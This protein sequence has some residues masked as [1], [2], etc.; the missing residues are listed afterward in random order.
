MWI[1]IKN[2]IKNPSDKIILKLF[3]LYFILKPFYFWE[4]G[5]PQIADFFLILAIVFYIFKKRFLIRFHKGSSSYIYINL[6]FVF[7][8]L[9]V[10][11]FWSLILNGELDFYKA[12]AFYFF[13][14]MAS[15]FVVI[16]YW[17]YED[18]IFQLIYSS[19]LSSIIIQFAIYLFKGGFR[20]SRVLVFFNNPNQLGYY[21]LLTLAILLY[22]SFKMKTITV[23]FFIGIF[24]ATAL[25]FASLSKAAIVS[26]TGMLIYFI[27]IKRKNKIFARKVIIFLLLAIVLSVVLYQHNSNIIRSNTLLQGVYRRILTIGLDYDD[28]LYARGYDRIINYPYYLVFGAGEGVYSRFGSNTELHSTLG[29]VLM[30][31]G[32][33]GLDIFLI[34]IFIVFKQNR[35]QD[36]YLLLFIMVYGLTHNGIRNTLFWI[37]ISL[38]NVGS[39]KLGKENL[40]NRHTNG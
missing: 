16:L 14:F 17:E 8:V 35:W 3:S 28:S 30:S 39:I 29:N 9:L 2:T 26:Y 11:T 21:S 15:L 7:Y 34:L 20:D 10:N 4:S 37:L 31:Y 19:V 24:A 38:I 13:N 22:I 27:F 5:I 33:I 1:G 25:C 36:L 40:S 12:S 32:V 6:V 18:V 23:M